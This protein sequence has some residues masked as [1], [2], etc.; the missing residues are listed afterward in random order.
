MKSKH[1]CN[2]TELLRTV[3]KTNNT[4][5]ICSQKNEHVMNTLVVGY[6]F[7]KPVMYKK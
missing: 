1:R 2:Q 5:Y 3:L 7:K 6:K 4:D